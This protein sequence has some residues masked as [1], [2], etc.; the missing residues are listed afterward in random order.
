MDTLKAITRFHV[1]YLVLT[2]VLTVFSHI[3]GRGYVV[4]ALIPY[5]VIKYIE[6][7]NYLL[8]QAKYL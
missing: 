2:T 6:L 1:F 8:E 5:V 3:E 7:M 4:Q